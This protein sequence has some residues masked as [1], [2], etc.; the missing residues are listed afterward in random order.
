MDSTHVIRQVL[1]AIV[2]AINARVFLDAACGDFN[3]MKELDLGV[4]RY[5]GSDIVADLIAE[6][7][8]KYGDRIR[9]FRCLDIVKDALP[10]SD[11]VLCRDCLAHLSYEDIVAAIGNI[12]ASGAT[13]LLA[14]TFPRMIENNLDIRT[15]DFR[16]VN[17]QAAPFN[18]PVP[19]MY[20]EEV[21]AEDNMVYWK[22][23]LCLW[24]LTDIVV[25]GEHEFAE[26]MKGVKVGS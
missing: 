4:E 20:F 21:S 22:K 19:I 17:L 14:S 1:P 11:V 18:F 23:T 26:H 13:Y 25:P 16:P 7:Q 5:I 10:R 3:W 2:R 8:R 9:E 15:G 24:R 6:N 12:K